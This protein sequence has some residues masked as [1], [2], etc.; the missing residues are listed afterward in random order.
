MSFDRLRYDDD[1]YVHKLKES[2][3]AGQYMIG[4]PK[5]NCNDCAYYAPGIALDRRGAAVCEKEL[6]DVDSELLN[7]SRKASHCPGKKY[8]PQE[9][10]FC[11]PRLLKDCDFLTPEDTRLS[12]PVCTGKES[13]INRFEWLCTQP[14]AHALVPFDHQINNRIIVKDAFRPC[15]PNPVDQ[16]AALP[17]EC[18]EYI[19]Y[20][21][22]SK[23]Q[24][25]TGI[26]MPGHQLATCK[27]IP[28]L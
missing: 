14:Q 20:D 26:S 21:W 25:R 7:I 8:L 17:P 3:G 13:T 1:A 9:K 4:T 6:V 12:N 28:L 11:Q 19:R 5:N 27:N 24:N 18:N 16:R 10:P 15:V 23:Y 2:I 22:W